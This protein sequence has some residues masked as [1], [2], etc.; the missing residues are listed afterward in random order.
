VTDV[1]PAL[2]LGVGSGDP[3]IMHRPPRP[4]GEPILTRS[5]WLRVMAFGTL[6]TASVLGAFAV[7]LFGLDLPVKDAITVS[8][9]T[10]A[11]AQLWHVFNMRGQGSRPLANEI[12][13][14]PFVWGALALC[15]AALALALYLPSAAALLQLTRPSRAAWL[16]V[17]A[18]STAPLIAGQVWLAVAGQA[19]RAGRPAPSTD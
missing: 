6:I 8:F 14:N 12:T 5:Q 2:A 1:F 9:L 13:R 16:V 17:A 18:F 4:P 7:A 11:L 10:L 15:I 19:F 3:A